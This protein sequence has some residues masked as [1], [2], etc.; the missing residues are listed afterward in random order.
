MTVKWKENVSSEQKM[1]GGGAQGSLPGILEYLSQNNSCG[2]F[3]DDEERYKFIDDLSILE[4]INLVNIGL[5]SYDV[6]SHIP[7]D[8]KTENNFLPPE[9]IKSQ[10][11]LQKIETWTS[12]KLMQLNTKKTQYMIINFTDKYQFNTRLELGGNLLEEVSKARLLG[13]HIDNRLTWQLN[14]TSIVQIL[15]MDF[16]SL[17]MPF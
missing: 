3:L 8:V 11:N 14:T 15:L 9:N 7:S 13:V 5:I 17:Q 2:D 16:D 4:I 12:K 10:G 1:N 6:L